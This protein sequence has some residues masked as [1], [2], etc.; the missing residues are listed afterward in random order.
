MYTSTDK[1]PAK[2]IAHSH[3]YNGYLVWKKILLW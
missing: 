2:S 1:L 3:M